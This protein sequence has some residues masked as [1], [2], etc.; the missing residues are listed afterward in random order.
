MFFLFDFIYIFYYTLK[1]KRLNFILFVEIKNKKGFKMFEAGLITGFFIGFN[2][3]A[4]IAFFAIICIGIFS[5]VNE[6][7]FILGLGFGFVYAVARFTEN[8]LYQVGLKSLVIGMALY[9]IIGFIWSIFK[10]KKESNR[11]ADRMIES[12]NKAKEK[13]KIKDISEYEFN[14]RTK[15]RKIDKEKIVDTINNRISLDRRFYWI[16]GWPFSVFGYFFYE[17]FIDLIKKL[18]KFYNIIIEKTVESKLQNIK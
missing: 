13:L 16:R 5:I 14:V 12:S 17:M 4:W 18:G 8:N 6:N 2:W 9:L 10:V 11:I 3:F 7:G 15:E 1:S